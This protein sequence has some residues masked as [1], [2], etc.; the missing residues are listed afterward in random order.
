LLLPRSIGRFG[1]SHEDGVISVRLDVF[2]EIL[3]TLE[4]LAAELALMRLQ[5][6]VDADVRRDV[7]SL[8][9]RRTTATP[10]TR[11]VEI[12]GALATDVAFADMV[13]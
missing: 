1:G 8:H 5:G 7:V 4:G 13:L 3:W 2:L 11:Q 10:L 12:V 9:R 6:H